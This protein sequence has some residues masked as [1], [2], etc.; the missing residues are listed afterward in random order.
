METVGE[1][2]REGGR[3]EWDGAYV[4]TAIKRLWKAGSSAVDSC[5]DQKHICVGLS[6][7]RAVQALSSLF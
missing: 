1:R 6:N 2:E 4:R 7:T 5:A 3:E